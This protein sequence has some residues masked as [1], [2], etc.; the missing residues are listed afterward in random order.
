MLLS[1]VSEKTVSEKFFEE[2]CRDNEIPIERV[3]AS[4]KP[5]E[6]RPDYTIRSAEEEIIVEV[7]QFDPNEQDLRIERQLNERGYGEAFG[8][9]PGARARLKIQSGARQLKARGGGLKPTMLVL[10]D[11]VPFGSRATDPY[12][13]KTAM[14]GIEKLDLAVGREHVSV[15]DRGFGPK[16]KMTPESNRSISA[17][18][19][20]IKPWN[21][22]ARLVVYHNLHAA[23]PLNWRAFQGPNI[24]HF[25]LSG[26][27]RGE[28]QEWTR[29]QDN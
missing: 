13:I 28:F 11:N 19:A 8:G 12:E 24:V 16:R 21:S 22:K 29:L 18:A 1:K 14:Y 7:K 6:R 20:L 5:D 3:E 27:R 4:D 9:E 23:V 10:Y 15:V 17:L 25:T 2:F 26:K